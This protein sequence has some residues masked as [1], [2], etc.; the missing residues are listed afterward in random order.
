MKKIDTRLL[1]FETQSLY[2][3]IYNKLYDYL[4][5]DDKFNFT[6][7]FNESEKRKYSDF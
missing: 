1:N 7:K 4:T 5:D 2:N 3:T 6:R